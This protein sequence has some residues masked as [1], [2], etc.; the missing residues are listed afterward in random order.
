MI[1]VYM[2][3]FNKAYKMYKIIQLILKGFTTNREESYDL[4]QKEKKMTMNGH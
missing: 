2:G 1:H 4:A 3:G